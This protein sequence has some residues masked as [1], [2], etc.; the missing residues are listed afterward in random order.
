MMDGLYQIAKMNVHIVADQ[1]TKNINEK[2]MSIGIR[3]LFTA[4]FLRQFF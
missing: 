2:R 1:K 3:F 4:A